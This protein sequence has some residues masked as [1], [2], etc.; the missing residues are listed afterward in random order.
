MRFKVV[1]APWAQSE[2]Y[3]HGWVGLGWDVTNGIKANLQVCIIWPIEGVS[4]FS[5][6]IPWDTMKIYIV[7]A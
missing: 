4:S 7:S 2:Q 3:L 6:A 1:R 5:P